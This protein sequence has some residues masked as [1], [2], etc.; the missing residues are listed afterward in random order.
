MTATWPAGSRA[1]GA[2][3][4]SCGVNIVRSSSFRLH[5]WPHLPCYHTDLCA[6]AIHPG[7]VVFV[8]DLECRIYLPASCGPAAGPGT[9]RLTGGGNLRGGT[10][11]PSPRT[12]PVSLP[13]THSPIHPHCPSHEPAQPTGWNNSAHP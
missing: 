1:T 10:L 9:A 7:L 5:L 12:L 2:T 13:R 8:R 3:V 4:K 6:G 11:P